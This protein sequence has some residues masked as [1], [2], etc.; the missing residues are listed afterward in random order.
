MNIPGQIRNP[1]IHLHF[2]PT[3][4]LV[5]TIPSPFHP[6]LDPTVH[7]HIVTTRTRI[8]TTEN[9]NFNPPSAR[10]APGSAREI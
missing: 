8:Y 10:V 7:L 9:I 3:H 2:V 6:R 5:P 1:I 4:A